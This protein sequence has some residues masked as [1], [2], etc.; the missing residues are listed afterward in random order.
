[1]LPNVLNQKV[2]VYTKVE[3]ENELG[4]IEYARA[5]VKTVWANIVHMST[6]VNDFVSETTVAD[7][8]FKFIIR[9]KSLKATRDMV[10]KYK[11]QEYFVEYVTPNFKNPDRVEVICKMEMV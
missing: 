2:D 5:F 1:M 6:K 4:Q 11:N 10:F 3:R 9:A 8:K 7:Y